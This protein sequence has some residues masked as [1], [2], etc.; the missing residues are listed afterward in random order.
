LLAAT[1]GHAKN[2]SIR[3][4]PG[5]RFQLTPLYDVLS[6]WP[7]IG[8]K[9][10]ELPL[11]KVKLA[12]ALPGQKPHYLLKSLQRRHFELLGVRMG[13]G[14]RTGEIIDATLASVRDVIASAQR[15][16]PAGFPQDLLER[17]LQG[18]RKTAAVLGG[19]AIRGP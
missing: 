19:E 16:L 1:D 4:L 17:V 5:G 14:A 9:A 18:V 11:E 12:M 6:A 3:L 2:F 7:V 10:N 8:R 13:L 15:G